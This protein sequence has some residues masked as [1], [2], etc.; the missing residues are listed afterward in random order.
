MSEE[1]V[2][3]VRFFRL[4]T[5]ARARMASEIFLGGKELTY[6]PGTKMFYVTITKQFFL[7]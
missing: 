2:L 7:K 3:P 6:H 1:G 4:T 5:D